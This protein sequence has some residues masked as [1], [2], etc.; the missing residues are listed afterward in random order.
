MK[1]LAIS[2]TAPL[3]S[4]GN[5]ATFDQRFT[6]DYPS[7]SAV[8]GLLAAALGYRRYD[9]RIMDLNALQF[10]VRT[11]QV[12]QLLTDF[13]T[14]QMNT[15]NKKISFRGYLQDARF[16][17]AVGSENETMIAKLSDA[18]ARPKFQ[19]FLGRRANAPAGPVQTE[20]FD[21]NPVEALQALRWQAA[22]WYQQR[23]AQSVQL[24][25][26]ADAE[27]LPDASCEQVKDW[28]ESLNQQNRQYGFRPAAVSSVTIN[29]PHAR[30]EPDFFS[31]VY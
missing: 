1:T 10:A 15:K 4:Y 20:I 3:Q 25:I 9:H 30:P 31:S 7:R 2:L 19:L 26:V 5:E 27:L 8:V 12:G 24:L 23:Q 22:C 11:D 13:Q 29:N 18:L 17:V 6:G 16:V 28:T 14:M 21:G